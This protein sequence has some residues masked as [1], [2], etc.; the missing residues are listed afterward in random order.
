[1]PRLASIS[2]TGAPPIRAEDQ[3]KTLEVPYSK[4][5]GLSIFENGL[6]VQ[7]TNRQRTLT[8]A[9]APGA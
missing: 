5:A 3:R 4:L 2:V 9:K 8:A 6:A 7:A 1:M